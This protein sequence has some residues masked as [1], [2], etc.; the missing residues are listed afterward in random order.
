MNRNPDKVGFQ[1]LVFPL[2]DPH[3]RV[4]AAT[5][6]RVAMKPNRGS[7]GV[8]DHLPFCLEERMLSV[9]RKK[10]EESVMSKIMKIGSAVLFPP[11]PRP[12]GDA[13]AVSLD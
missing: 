8:A 3:V 6:Y 1:F 7:A 2:L 10:D 11:G 12:F 4:A 9:G 13:N 5:A